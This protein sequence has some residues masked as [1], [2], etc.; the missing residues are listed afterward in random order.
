M[1]I[2]A[3]RRAALFCAT[4]AALLLGALPS[5]QAQAWPNRSV[6]IVVPFPP[7]GGTDTGTRLVAQRLSQKWGQPVVVENRPGAAGAIGADYVA[8]ARPDGYVLLMGNLGTQSVNPSLYK[9]PYASDTA[10]AP[11]S[12][13]AELPLVLA[14]NPNVAARTL[15]ELIALA[16]SRKPGLSY[17]S[18]GAGGGPH[19]AGE[20][21]ERAAGLQLLHV[22]YKGG[23]PMV[24]DLI[25]GHV[26]LSF[27]TV[28]EAS[29]HVKSGKL[30]AIGVTSDKRS[31]SMPEVP[32]LAE[33]GLPG[34]QAA[35]WIGLLAPAG[36]PR[37]IVDKVAADVAEVVAH[38]DLNQ[39]LSAQ[40]A[41]PV[42]GTP[43]QFSALI[44]SDRQRYAR[45]IREKAI[46]VE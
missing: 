24:A 26:D 40:G 42:G 35:S 8:K 36:T 41:T 18:S 23:G 13:V 29:G 19:L 21:F 38:P 28:L 1:T 7:G 46:T 11:I 31:P 30:R 44:E 37:E 34:F 32:T 3:T 9:L 45:V 33:S 17:S 22:P 20:L 12:L 4:A 43:A 27:P 6:T 5:A 2:N 25:G 14:V 10:F 16:R 15:P 39:Q